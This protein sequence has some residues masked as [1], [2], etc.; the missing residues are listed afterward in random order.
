MMSMV[1][2]VVVTDMLG[3]I[4]MG[5]VVIVYS[6]DESVGGVHSMVTVELSL[7]FTMSTTLTSA[8]AG[9]DKEQN[10]T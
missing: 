8:G 4:G 10:L 6:R 9:A 7:P 3:D 2:D 1:G 5:V